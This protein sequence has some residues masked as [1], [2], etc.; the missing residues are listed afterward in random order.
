MSMRAKIQR[1][2]RGVMLVS[3]EP[4]FDQ[5][6]DG[7][8]VEVSSNGGAFMVTPIQD[9]DRERL[10]RESSGKVLETHAGLFRRLS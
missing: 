3:D 1:V 2:D 8:E 5:L 9:A 4:L 10:F 7:D 6:G